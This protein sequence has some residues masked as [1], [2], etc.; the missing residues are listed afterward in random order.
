VAEWSIPFD[1]LAAKAKRS[2]EE[3]VRL[4]TMEM[5][6]RVL[7]RSPVDTGR[8]RANWNASYGAMDTTVSEETA[9]PRAKVHNAILSFPVGGIVYLANSLPYAMTLEYGLYPNPA[10][11]GS[12]KRGE[13]RATIHTAGGYSMQAPHGMVRLTAAEFANAVDILVKTGK[14][15]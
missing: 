11:Y 14:A 13:R 4:S 7:F 12:K 2:I 1:V 10:K 9:D 5:F 6:G 8:F 15:T 3:T